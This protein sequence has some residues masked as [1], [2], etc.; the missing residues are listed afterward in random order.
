MS[1]LQWRNRLARG[2][3]TAVLEPSNAEVVSSSLTWSTELF[4]EGEGGF[5]GERS[6][7]RGE[8]R[9]AHGKI[10]RG[11]ARVHHAGPG[12]CWSTAEGRLREAER[13]A[14]GREGRRAAPAGGRALKDASASMETRW[15]L[16]WLAWPFGAE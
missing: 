1:G 2:T 10:M 3:Y 13:A 16:R 8:T 7:G 6:A 14:G 5:F 11:P 9:K 12:R 4:W 15:G